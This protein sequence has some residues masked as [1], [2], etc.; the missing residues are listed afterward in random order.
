MGIKQQNVNSTLWGLEV[1]KE[2]TLGTD[3]LHGMLKFVLAVRGF[4]SMLFENKSDI[5]TK[6][7][8]VGIGEMKKNSG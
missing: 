8:I 3:I 7:R 6:E 1:N 4:L 5:K 2:Q